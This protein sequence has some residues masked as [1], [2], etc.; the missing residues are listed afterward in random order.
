MDLGDD[1]IIDKNILIDKD[2]PIEIPSETR[3]VTA[4]ELN[5]RDRM[6]FYRH[7]D[8]AAVCMRPTEV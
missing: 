2:T 6:H 8:Y 3:R 1:C 5:G 4:W 7:P